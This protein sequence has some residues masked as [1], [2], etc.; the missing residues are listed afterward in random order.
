MITYNRLWVTMK[1]KN[2]SQYKLIKDYNFSRGQIFRLRHNHNVNTNTL[3][4]LCNILD[5]NV[6]DIMK[7][8]KDENKIY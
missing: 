7:F 8:T 3:N 4:T 1:E 6:E 2:V 5:C